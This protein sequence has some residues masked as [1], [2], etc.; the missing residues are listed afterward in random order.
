MA[1]FKM[2]GQLL[3]AEVEERDEVYCPFVKQQAGGR[4]G[5]EERK[6]EGED[7]GSLTGRNRVR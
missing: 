5:D 4:G 6:E 2:R 7:N 3:L 1:A